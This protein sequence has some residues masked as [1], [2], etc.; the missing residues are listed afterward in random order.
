[1]FY[2]PQNCICLINVHFPSFECSLFVTNDATVD[3]PS[4]LLFLG[5]WEN[6]RFQQHSSATVQG[7][8]VGGEM[9]GR[10]LNVSDTPS[11]EHWWFPLRTL[12]RQEAGMRA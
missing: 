2:G 12:G 6:R 5:V 4:E 11:T 3:L 1:M 10:N 7:D 9:K 8:C